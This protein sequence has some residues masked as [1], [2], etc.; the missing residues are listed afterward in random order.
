MIKSAL[1]SGYVKLGG[2][3]KRADMGTPQGS[4]LS[5]VL[6]NIYL[7]KLDEFM[8]QTCEE[9]SK[10]NRRRQNPEY[11]KT[12]KILNE[13]AQDRPNIA[14]KLELRK[15][16]TKIRSTDPYDEKYIRVRYVRYAD[17]FIISILGPIKLA[18]EIRDKTGE[19]LKNTLQLELNE[20][21]TIITEAKK[22]PAHFLGTEIRIRSPEQKPVKRITKTGP[23][24]VGTSPRMDLHAPIEQIIKRL[25]NKFFLKRSPSSRSVIPTGVK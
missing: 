3:A 4:N 16:K 19:W 18:K 11:T 22:K 8:E 5:P 1:K 9:Q 21:K 20:G 24:T 15:S 25:E 14:R 7:H 2:H 17:D 6:C 13:M 23:K 12:T 10:G